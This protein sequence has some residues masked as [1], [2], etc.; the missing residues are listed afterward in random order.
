MLIKL[1]FST[2]KT[3]AQIWRVVAD[4]IQTTSVNSIAALRVRQTAA[5]YNAD[6]LQGLVDAT[7]Y[8]VRSNDITSNTS[9]H[10]ARPN[11]GSGNYAFEFI[12]KQKVYDAA[13]T[14]VVSLSSTLSTGT[15]FTSTVGTT[16]GDTSANQWDITT[17]STQTT[18]QGSVLG[19][20][21]TLSPTFNAGATT[22]ADGRIFTI[23][24]YLTDTCFIWAANRDTYTISGA[25]TSGWDPRLYWNGPHIY[26]QY[27]R[28]DYWNTDAN[29]IIPLVFTQHSTAAF[30]YGGGKTYGEG[31]LSRDTELAY[32]QNPVATQPGNVTFQFLNSVDNT[33]LASTAPRSILTTPLAVLG[34]ATKWSD[35]YPLGRNAY[36]SAAQPSVSSLN[37][38]DGFVVA[39]T[40]LNGQSQGVLDRSN[41]RYVSDDLQSFYG[42][43]LYPM[44]VRNSWYNING[45][46]ITDKS[47]VYL[48]NGDFFPGDEVTVGGI[49]YALLPV[50]MNSMPTATNVSPTVSAGT[51]SRVALAIPKN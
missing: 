24:V 8:I 46:N 26:S 19:V 37:R 28:G 48:F 31:F 14:Y 9:C 18:S 12:L 39:Y 7:S 36:T 30:P 50:G 51:Q 4:I 32:V 11:V 42:Y 43:I 49:T 16:T 45:G 13:S 34:I 21:G 20:G 29:G 2:A 15:Y 41:Y 1:N 10:I 3:A 23:W 6:L 33:L 35:Y 27:T 38:Y 25:P 47:G 44:S 17:S 5:N 40:S 22:Q